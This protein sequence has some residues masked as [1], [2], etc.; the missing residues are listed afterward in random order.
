MNTIIGNSSYI[1]RHTQQAGKQNHI[2]TGNGNWGHAAESVYEDAGGLKTKDS[3]ITAQEA[4]ERVGN[5]GKTLPETGREE[6]YKDKSVEVSDTEQLPTK[7]DEI[8]IL[9][10]TDIEVVSLHNG[11]SFYY[12]CDTGE[13]QCINHNDGRPGRHALWSKTLTYEDWER[14]CGEMLDRYADRAAGQFVY[15]YQ[16]Y[17]RHE[18]FWD[19][20]L[21]GKVDLRTLTEKDAALSEEE[22]YNKFLRD[23]VNREK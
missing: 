17:L 8:E 2:R 21:D 11:V 6:E 12:N 5:S 14:C 3:G 15:R 13:L 18:E 10:V 7:E 20:Y 22:L 9:K 19:M 4:Y 16:A 23:M 1:Y